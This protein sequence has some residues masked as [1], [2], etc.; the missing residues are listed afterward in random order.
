MMTMKK[1]AFG[2]ALSTALTA[3][4]ASALGPPNPVYDAVGTYYL[5][6]LGNARLPALLLEDSSVRIYVT[7]GTLDLRRDGSFKETTL[8]VTTYAYGPVGQKDT[9]ITR[10]RFSVEGTQWTFMVPQNGAVPGYSY[11]A[12]TAYTGFKTE[13]ELR[14]TRDGVARKYTGG[15][16]P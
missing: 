4:G 6:S 5:T 2:L 10:G 13:R 14:L 12:A 3:C 9:V 16:W 8:T 15:L 1:L 11:V 7:D